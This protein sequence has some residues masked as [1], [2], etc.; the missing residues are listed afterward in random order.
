MAPPSLGNS[1]PP[2]GRGDPLN[3]AAWLRAI[4]ANTVVTA[5]AAGAVI[6]AI[7]V[8]TACGDRAETDRSVTEIARF[9]PHLSSG[10]EV[11]APCHA[12]AFDLWKGSHHDLAM[13]TVDETSVLGDFDGCAISRTSA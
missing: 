6:A 13:Q 4:A 3:R 5:V 10:G 7:A 8:L 11:C 12:A 9:P 1:A 2:A